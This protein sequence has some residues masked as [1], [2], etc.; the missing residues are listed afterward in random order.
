MYMWSFH[1]IQLSYTPSSARR[2]GGVEN[3]GHFNLYPSDDNLVRGLVAMVKRF[4]W[5]QI[6]ILTQD[7]QPFPQVK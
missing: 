6:S 5:S 7:V 2:V 4:R 1:P 3:N